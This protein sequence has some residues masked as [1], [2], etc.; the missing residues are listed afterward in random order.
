M[1]ALQ[2]RF[3]GFPRVSRA[4]LCAR[5]DLKGVSEAFPEVSEHFGLVSEACFSCT[6]H[7]LRGGFMGN[8]EAFQEVS[9]HFRQDSGTLYRCFQEFWRASYALYGVLGDL[10]R[11]LEVFQD[12]S[13]HFRRDSEA[14]RER[15][16]GVF[17]GFKA[18]K[19][20]YMGFEGVSRGSCRH[21][22][23]CQ[24]IFRDPITISFGSSLKCLLI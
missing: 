17:G 5:V 10:R 16:G 14:L 7:G 3:R 19:V 23:W 1:E 12:V 8:L 24:M 20:R 15:Y 2:V 21:F 4:L 6:L 11:I 22:R 9:E 13:E 18:S